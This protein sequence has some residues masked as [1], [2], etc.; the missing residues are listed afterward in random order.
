[1]SDPA[2][3]HERTDE[4]QGTSLTGMSSQETLR[5]TW[6]GWVKSS[7]GYS[8][9]VGSRTGIDYRDDRGSF[10]IDSEVMSEPFN[11][12]VVYTGSIPDTPERPQSE[13]LARLSKA[14]QHAGLVLTLE[15]AWLE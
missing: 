9:R 4:G 2:Q 1:M 15:D 8:L 7:E 13:V 3:R 14:F 6:R 12:V 10:H 11:E 5:T